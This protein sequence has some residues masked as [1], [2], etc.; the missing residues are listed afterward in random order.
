MKDNKLGNKI[1]ELRKKKKI[2]QRDLAN[3]LNTS[4]KVISR[5]EVG[6]SNPSLEMIFQMSKIFKVPYNELIMARVTYE[7]PKEQDIVKEILR[8]FE[9]VK[10]RKWE[11]IK[12]ISLV[13]S[14]L[15]LII[16]IIEMIFKIK[17]SF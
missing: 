1:C 5:W 12:I 2:T 15:R 3:A 17:C 14:F 7:S 13:V 6:L 8:D 16:S 4:D 10:K 11:V 9:N